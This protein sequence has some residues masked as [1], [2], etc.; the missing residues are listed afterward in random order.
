MVTDDQG[1][2]H[3]QNV[4][5][6]YDAELFDELFFHDK[7]MTYRPADEGEVTA[8]ENVYGTDS[9]K[10]DVAHVQI[11]VNGKH[12]SVDTPEQLGTVQSFNQIHRVANSGSMTEDEHQFPRECRQISKLIDLRELAITPILSE[13]EGYLGNGIY[14]DRTHLI[15][16]SYHVKRTMENYHH[17]VKALAHLA[18]RYVLGI[19][20]VQQVLEEPDTSSAVDRRDRRTKRDT[21][22]TFCKALSPIPN[23][24]K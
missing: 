9:K 20:T 4:V 3:L 19:P 11:V 6:I 14:A 22:S 15:H 1:N 23:G 13:L 12:E 8:G 10:G 18:Q 16:H 5:E 24:M 2:D 21:G 17:E 7:H